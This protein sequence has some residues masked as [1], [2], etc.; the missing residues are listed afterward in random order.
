M[1]NTY[2]VRV[3]CV[4]CGEFNTIEVR[5]GDRVTEELCP[6]CGCEAL[7]LANKP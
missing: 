2:K 3:G 5:K 4:N 7:L 1:D 6:N